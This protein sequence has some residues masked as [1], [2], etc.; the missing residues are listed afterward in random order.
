LEATQVASVT[1]EKRL[2]MRH[3]GRVVADLSRAF[4]NSNGA[5]KWADLR[6]DALPLPVPPLAAPAG[7]GFAEKMAALVGDLNRCS[8]RGLAQRFDSTIGAATVLMPH[9]GRYQLTPEQAMVMKLPVEGETATCAGMAYGFDPYLSE[10][11]P[12]TGAYLAV[13]DSVARL[14]AAGFELADITLSFQEYFERLGADPARWGKP[15]AALLGALQA[16]LDLGVAAIGGKD[17]MSGSFEKLDVPPTLVSFAVAGGKVENVAPGAFQLPQS[18]VILLKPASADGLAPNATSF[19]LVLGQLAGLI[20]EK[21]V[22]SVRSVGGEGLASAV[23]NMCLGNRLG[24]A[25]ADGF[26]E[27]RLFAPCFGGFLVEL[28]G[29]AAVGETLGETTGHYALELGGQ[30]VHLEALQKLWEDR[31]EPV[32]PTAPPQAAEKPEPVEALSF[33]LEAGQRRAP[34]LGVAKPKALVPVFPGTNCEYDTARALAAAGAEAEIFVVRNLSPAAVAESAALLAEKIRESQMV[35]LPGGFSGG[36]EPEGSAKLICAF[37]RGGAVKD[38]V[39]DLLENRDGL[40][41]GICNGFQALVKLGL[42]PYGEIRDAAPD[43]HSGAQSAPTLTFNT[44]GRH[45]SM[46]CRTRVASNLSPWLAKEQVGTVHT[47][48]ISHGEGRFVAPPALLSQLAAAGQIATQYVDTTGAPTM[49]AAGNPN[50]ST[51]AIEGITSRDGRVLG[52]MG[53]TERTGNGLY[54][55]V[56][57]GKGQRLFEGG[58]DY[59]KI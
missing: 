14:C 44:I 47:I 9:A 50:G 57:V 18:R 24:F 16:Q 32:F 23:F 30:H 55:N 4:L 26:D 39:A 36:D 12:Y 19:K 3:G 41:L 21:K 43:S 27:D 2:V 31:L 56:P 45:Q 46:L 25:F 22:L 34:K 49:A 33:E 17:S 5:E 29:E 59:F 40:M 1:E 6:V 20:R 52:K 48:A 58:V 35:V 10:Q 11:N 42:L 7:A 15:F 28:D 37:F 38:A 8:Q 13:V 51:L 54:K 53:H